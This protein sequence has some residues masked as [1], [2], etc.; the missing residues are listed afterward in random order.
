[1]LFVKNLFT[2]NKPMNRDNPEKEDI[3][4]EIIEANFMIAWE[5]FTEEELDYL[6]SLYIDDN[7][8]ISYSSWKINNTLDYD[9]YIDPI[10]DKLR[11]LYKA[12]ANPKVEEIIEDLDTF[13]EHLE[14][15]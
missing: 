12:T 3:Q 2:N 4:D 14:N 5:W 10:K 1:M 15:S 8:D 7:I 11:Q 9:S 13:L 6:P